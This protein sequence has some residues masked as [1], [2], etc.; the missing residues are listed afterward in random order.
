MKNFF[1][2]LLSAWFAVAFSACKTSKKKKQKY[3]VGFYHELKDSFY[4]A[5]LSLVDDSIKLVFPDDIIFDVGSAAIKES[6]LTKLAMLSKL[7]TKYEKTNILI[8]GHTDNTGEGEV[9]DRLSKFRAESVKFKMIANEVVEKRIFVWGF[10]ARMPRN[11]NDTEEG[12]A[13]NRRV[14]FVLLYQISG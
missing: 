11:S 5:D 10:G 2:L 8:T 4:N 1:L 3:I 7:V 12:K 9:N 6:F 14:E 13:R